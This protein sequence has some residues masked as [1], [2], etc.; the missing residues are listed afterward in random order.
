MSGVYIR[1]RMSFY[2]VRLRARL[3]MSSVPSGG[4]STYRDSPRGHPNIMFAILYVGQNRELVHV[5]HV[6][7]SLVSTSFSHTF[8]L[9]FIFTE[10]VFRY[11]ALGLC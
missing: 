9:D 11:K 6:T 2:I 3:A 4:G 8:L 1:S 7:P 10:I 5:V